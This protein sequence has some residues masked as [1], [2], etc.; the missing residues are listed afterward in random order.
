M[1]GRVERVN[2]NIL[3]ECREQIGVDL[4][5]IS[6]KIQKIE[7]LEQGKLKPTFKQLN[8]IVAFY[9]VPRWVFLSEKL[10]EK[11]QFAKTIPEFRQFSDNRDSFNHY[12]VRGL[13]AKIERFRSLILELREIV[14]QVK[15]T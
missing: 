4:F 9:K 2:P 1:S 14:W 8:A 10:P 6:K 12:K 3:R 7:E 5:E 11:Y 15:S 13:T